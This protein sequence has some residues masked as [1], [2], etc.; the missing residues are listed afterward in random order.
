MVLLQQ[1][2]FYFYVSVWYFFFDIIEQQDFKQW[3]TYGGADR[4]SDPPTSIFA[5][6]NSEQKSRRPPILSE[7]FYTLPIPTYPAPTY[8]QSRI[9]P[10]IMRNQQTSLQSLRASSHAKELVSGGAYLIEAIL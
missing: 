2:F 4:A 3:R 8:P 9:I 10:P 5:N 1:F 7:E 6:E